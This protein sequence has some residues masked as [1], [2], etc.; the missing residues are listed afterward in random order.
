MKDRET[1]TNTRNAHERACEGKRD[2]LAS[3]DLSML[4][5]HSQYKGIQ[6]EIKTISHHNFDYTIPSIKNGIRSIS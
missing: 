6:Q 2:Q 4:L 3:Y 1:H 5:S